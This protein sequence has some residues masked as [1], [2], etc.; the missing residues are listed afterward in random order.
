[1]TKPQV[2]YTLYLV[3]DRSL[4][5]AGTTLASSVKAAI[6]GGATLVQLREKNV[7]TKEF[8][9]TAQQV[10]AITRAAGVPLFIND[11]IDVALAVDADGV[12][13]G[14]SDMPVDI[15]RGLLGSTKV[16]GVTVEN[17]QQA[18]DAIQKG[19]DYIGTSAVFPTGTK[20]HADDHQFLGP[21]GVKAI[22][23]SVRYTDIPVVTIGGLNADNVEQVLLESAVEKS[24]HKP[25]KR[26]SGVAIVSAI[27]AKEDPKAA[28]QVLA[29]KIRPIVSG[30][31]HAAV[32]RSLVW[33][34]PDAE[35]ALV[36]KIANAFIQLRERK[37]LVHNITNY[38]VMNDTA[39]VILHIGGL[40]VMAHAH[41]EAAKIT[42]IS[43]ALVI[44]IG[45]LDDP[46]VQSMHISAKQANEKGIPIVLDPVGAGA[47]SYRTETTLKLLT[48]NKIDIVKGNAGEVGI[49]A[50]C[51]GVEMRG[52]ESVGTLSQPEFVVESLAKRFSNVFAISGKTDYISNGAQ[53]V[54]A[55]NGN[56]WLGTLTGTGCSTTTLVAS[57]AAVE[58][59][60]VVATVAGIVA[61]GVAAELAV[62]SGR[63]AGPASFKAALYDALYHLN[64]DAIRLR[65]RVEILKS[66]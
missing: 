32:E 19:A 18:W 12:H 24:G 52:V 58:K 13:I 45:T 10:L 62:E 63:V 65:A 14:Q 53:T 11:R 30:T 55:S 28:S 64:A 36:D 39:N 60:H 1:M 3:T 35:Q 46:K 29:A 21:V 5:P 44:N 43:N 50:G 20:K 22:L 27:I 66:A 49:I 8:V 48:E 47:T 59:D 26:L 51:G 2:D 42:G 54:A 25:A 34:R 38:V 41:N 23:E 9:E 4:L 31:A 61:M 17:P 56:E 40:P 7:S 33:K 57:F 6:E 37:P 16:L 15:A